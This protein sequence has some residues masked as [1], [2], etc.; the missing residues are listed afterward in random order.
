MTKYAPVSQKK[1]RDYIR[2]FL[3]QMARKDFVNSELWMKY[4]L[5]FQFDIQMKR[6]TTERL[7]V[8]LDPKKCAEVLKTTQRTKL[9]AFFNEDK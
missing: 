9:E 8:A 5:Y 6:G 4:H 3:L 1:M 7:V 2:A